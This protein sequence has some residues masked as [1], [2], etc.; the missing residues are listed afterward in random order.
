MLAQKGDDYLNAE[1]WTG[2]K[3]CLMTTENQASMTITK[4]DVPEGLPKKAD[5][6]I[7]PA[8][9]TGGGPSCLEGS[10][11]RSDPAVMPSDDLGGCRQDHQ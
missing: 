1:G 2:V 3:S 4:Q 5:P 6:A 9:G 11:S 7:C 10:T 8:D